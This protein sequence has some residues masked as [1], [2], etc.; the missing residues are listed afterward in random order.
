MPGAKVACPRMR[1]VVLRNSPRDDQ[2]M[3]T[4]PMRVDKGTPDLGILIGTTDLCCKLL[5]C[6]SFVPGNAK[7]IGC[8]LRFCRGPEGSRTPDLTRARETKLDPSTSANVRLPC[9]D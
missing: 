1:R 7:Q 9:S 6:E 5:G 3:T 2:M 8:D 4:R